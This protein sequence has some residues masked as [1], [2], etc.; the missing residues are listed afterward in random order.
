VVTIPGAA[1]PERS[2]TTVHLHIGGALEPLLHAAALDDD[3]AFSGMG[4]LAFLV[5]AGSGYVLRAVDAREVEEELELLED[6][7]YLHRTDSGTEIYLPKRA[8]CGD[9]TCLAC[10]FRAVAQ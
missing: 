2:D 10:T 9:L 3:I 5:A 1:R 7:G 4:F 8:A 6:A